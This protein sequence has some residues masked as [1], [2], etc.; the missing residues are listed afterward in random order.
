MLLLQLYERFSFIFLFLLLTAI[1]FVI[2]KIS[3]FINK[4]KIL[5]DLTKY[6]DIFKATFNFCFVIDL[7]NFQI[8][9]EKFP[10]AIFNSFILSS[11]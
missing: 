2:E 10:L 1:Y 5:C 8:F 11:N 7:L 9:S 4:F 6:F 3:F